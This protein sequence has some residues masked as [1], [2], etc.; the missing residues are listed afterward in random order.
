[1]TNKLLQQLDELPV[2][3][4]VVFSSPIEK[5]LVRTVTT[6]DHSFFHA[7]LYACLHNYKL[8]N[9]K[10]RVKLI[11]EL[12]SYII[13]K[14]YKTVPCVKTYTMFLEETIIMLLSNFYNFMST[15]KCNKLKS[16]K[17]IR[18]KVIINESDI[19]TYKFITE[20]IT[21]DE[22]KNNIL[23][24]TSNNVDAIKQFQPLKETLDEYN[25]KL[26]TKKISILI[27]AVVKE[28]NKYISENYKIN[29]DSKTIKLISNKLNIDIY[30]IDSKTRMPCKSSN[31]KKRKSIIIM[32]NENG[33]CDIVG[34]LLPD[35][36]IKREFDHKESIITKIYS[37]LY[38]KKD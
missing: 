19:K 27:K 36:R 33:H 20:M 26:Y 37:H 6:H 5:N 15:G 10:N 16:S 7:V 22:L 28:S 8:I 18:K 25:K 4:I 24:I 13:N 30:F 32:L 17:K 23:L 29:I 11:N 35:S 1:M 12:R 9:T 21:I 38:K 34:K 3:K 31:I 2:N 14:L